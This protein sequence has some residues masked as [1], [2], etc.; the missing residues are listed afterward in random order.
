MLIETLHLG[1]ATSIAL[2]HDSIC[3]VKTTPPFVIRLVYY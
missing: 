1:G 3:A 2:I